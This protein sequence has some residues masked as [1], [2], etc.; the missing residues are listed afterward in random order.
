M[1]WQITSTTP[2]RRMILHFSHIGLTDGL[3]FMI[4]FRLRFFP[5]PGSGCRTGRR[6]RAGNT[7]TR[8][9]TRAVAQDIAS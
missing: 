5:R 6:Y 1:F 9:Y 3:T 7:L 4:P 8:A 2:L